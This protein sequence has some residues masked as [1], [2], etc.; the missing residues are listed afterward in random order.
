MEPSTTIAVVDTVGP[1]YQRLVQEVGPLAATLFLFLAAGGWLSWRISIAV[2]DAWQIE[3]Q[4]H[5]ES[6]KEERLLHRDDINK[7]VDRLDERDRFQREELVSLV[8]A[9]E[10]VT[11][12]QIAALEKIEAVLDPINRGILTRPCMLHDQKREI[13]D[14]ARVEAE[15]MI[16]SIEGTQSHERHNHQ[17]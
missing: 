14:A 12:S 8:R 3:G 4:R 9:Y 11:V 6:M 7:L 5:R 2:L 16:R 13:L 10:K 17:R 1:W 15:Q